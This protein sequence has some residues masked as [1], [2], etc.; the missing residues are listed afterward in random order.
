MSI[1]QK[2]VFTSETKEGCFGEMISQIHLIF[3][4]MHSLLNKQAPQCFGHVQKEPHGMLGM[5]NVQSVRPQKPGASECT[6]FCP[7]I[8]DE[9]TDF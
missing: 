6:L 9:L 5:R 2:P 1:L 7:H 4:A 3:K 8:L